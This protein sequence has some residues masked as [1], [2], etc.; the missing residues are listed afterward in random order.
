VKPKEEVKSNVQIGKDSEDDFD[1][2]DGLN[3]D[4]EELADDD[5]F[6]MQQFKKPAASQQKPVSTV[7]KVSTSKESISITPKG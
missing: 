3:I 6:S 1:L 2:D 7:S 5:L 4:V